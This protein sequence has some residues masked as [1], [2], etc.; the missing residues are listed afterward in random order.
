VARTRNALEVSVV[1]LGPTIA[2][3]LSVSL[4]DVDGRPVALRGP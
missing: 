2:A 3:L 4:A 1:D